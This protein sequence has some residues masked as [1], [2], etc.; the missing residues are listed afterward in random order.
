MR[1]ISLVQSTQ[2]D[3]LP[4]ETDDSDVDEDSGK[5][6]VRRTH[7]GVAY[8]PQVIDDFYAPP[9]ESEDEDDQYRLRQ[10]LSSARTTKVW[11][12][13]SFGKPVFWSGAWS[14]ARS[15]LGPFRQI[16]SRHRF[17]HAP[18]R[19]SYATEI[20]L[21]IRLVTTLQTYYM[22][23]FI[24][25]QYAQELMKNLNIHSKYVA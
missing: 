12:A 8:G 7:A 11:V 22:P 5:T 2:P 25:N 15:V 3:D 21:C 10:I 14:N 9:E 20:A 16:H 1:L 6:P 19:Q 18:V 24:T 13:L 17:P 4:G 23:T